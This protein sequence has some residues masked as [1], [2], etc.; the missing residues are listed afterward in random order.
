MSDNNIQNSQRILN[1]KGDLPDEVI[2]I[3]Q[4]KTIINKHDAPMS[5]SEKCHCRRGSPYCCVNEYVTAS[6][7][8]HH[9]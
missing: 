6:H 5:Y 7:R 3:L 1:T 9:S 8:P 4:S 2:R